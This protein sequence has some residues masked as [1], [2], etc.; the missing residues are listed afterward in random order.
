MTPTQTIINQ[1][2]QDTEH[3]TKDELTEYYTLLDKQIM[4]L[5]D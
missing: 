5:V 2:E 1:I 4:R 3:M